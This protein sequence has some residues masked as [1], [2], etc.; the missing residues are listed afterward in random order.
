MID[1]VVRYLRSQGV[2]FRLSSYPAPE[3]LPEVAHRLPPGGLRV[4]THVLLVGGR[5][6]IA[7]MARG[8]QLNLPRLTHELGTTVLEGSAEDLPPPYTNVA[9]PIPPFGAEIGTLTIVDEAVTLAASIGFDTFSSTDIMDIVYD[10]FSRLERP[11]V[12]SFA[13]D[14]ELPASTQASG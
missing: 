6:A 1:R 5:P 7:C 9:G 10:D 4:V 11:R 2:P 12:A 8:A 14:G 13:I 3:A